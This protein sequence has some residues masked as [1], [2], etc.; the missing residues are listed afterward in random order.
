MAYERTL[1]E[2]AHL[3]WLAVLD[4]I[5]VDRSKQS[6]DLSLSDGVPMCDPCI[7]VL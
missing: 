4:F 7:V 6:D 2:N 1:R 5:P 3:S